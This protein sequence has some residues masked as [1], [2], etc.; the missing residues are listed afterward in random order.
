MLDLF[1]KFDLNIL[2]NDIEQLSK[3]ISEQKALEVNNGR[4]NG[5]TDD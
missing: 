2:D 4:G 1:A 3:I 5:G